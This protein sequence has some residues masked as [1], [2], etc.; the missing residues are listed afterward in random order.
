M[1]DQKLSDIP[2]RLTLADTTRLYGVNGTSSGYTVMDDVAAYIDDALIYEAPLTFST[3]LTRT[4]DTVSV[5]A[6]QN[7]TALSSLTANGFIKTSGGTGALSVDTT[8]YVPAT[9][10]VNG[11]ALSSD[12]TV[13]LSD[14]GLA[15]S[16][17]DNTIARFD[18]TSGHTQSSGIVIGD[19]DEISGFRAL[20]ATDSNTS[21][22][23]AATDT[24][25]TIRFTSASA[26]TVTLPNDLAVGFTVEII[27]SGAGRI[28]FSAASGA[29]IDNRQSQTKT[30]G[31]YAAVR[32]IVV[33]NSGGTAAVYNL[34]GDTG[35]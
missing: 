14:L 15:S 1:T 2:N 4:G 17:T 11:H 9:V 28:S 34:A 27:Q 35:A 13:T 10:T 8:A 26:V 20:I 24:G 23:L 30:Y 5:D 12:V 7:I 22:T 25:T 6:T 29:A 33:A 16:A 32:L 19:N 21:R 31:Q 18:G 3:G